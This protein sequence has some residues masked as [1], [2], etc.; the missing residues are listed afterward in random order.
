MTSPE[1]SIF[2]IGHST[3]GADRFLD[4]LIQHGIQVVVDVRSAPYS[5]YNP[6]Y[7]QI[8]LEA[9]L[10]NQGIRYLFLGKEL[11]ARSE[12]PGCYVGG[13]VQY[14]RIAQTESFRSGIE[15]VKK[16]SQSYRI[17]LM[18]SEKEP[19]EC[20]RT[21]LVSRVLSEEGMSVR[22]IHADGHLEE[23]DKAMNRLLELTSIPGQDLFRTRGELLEEALAKQ[24]SVVAYVDENLATGSVREEAP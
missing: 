1:H 8:A 11:G 19:L 4:L 21:L 15:R 16:G 2:T 5:R 24:E 12:D 6:Q 22:H 13:R 10:K 14:S 7:N 20:H 3:H 23:H 18:C 17:A 9:S